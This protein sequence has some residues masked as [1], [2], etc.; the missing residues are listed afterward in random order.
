MKKWK[1]KRKGKIEESGR[2]RVQKW[3][4]GGEEV[5]E[6]YRWKDIEDIERGYRREI[7]RPKERESDRSMRE[8]E[9]WE[10]L[11]G[12]MIRK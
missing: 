3:G 4:R 7:E 6:R 1:K 12:G 10:R 9:I 5:G 11:Q 8:G 2:A